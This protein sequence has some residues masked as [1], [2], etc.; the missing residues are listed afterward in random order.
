[1]DIKSFIASTDYQDFKEFMLESFSKKINAI[2][3]K[4]LTD[5]QIAVEVRGAQL[6]EQS[7][8]KAFRDFESQVQ[9]DITAPQKFI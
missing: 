8:I 3:T 5:N 7:L 2:D 4:A 1:M 6:A 9:K